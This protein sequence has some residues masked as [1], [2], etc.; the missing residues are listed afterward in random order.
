MIMLLARSFRNCSTLCALMILQVLQSSASISTPRYVK[1]SWMLR[2][3][4]ERHL[5]K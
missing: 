1:W 4:M 3:N 2:L 5:G